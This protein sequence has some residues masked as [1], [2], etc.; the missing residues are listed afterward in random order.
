MYTFF[1]HLHHYLSYLLIAVIVFNLVRA[2]IGFWGKKSWNSTDNL[3]SLVMTI[4]TDVQVVFG[5]ILYVFLSPITKAAFANFGMAMQTSALRFYLVEH[6]ATM[7]IALALF[8]IGRSKAKKASL[9]S[10]KHKFSLI[11]TAIGTLFLL[12]RLP[13]DKLL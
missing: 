12:M 11:F 8:H 13:Y 1:L 10:A 5:L 3:A 6:I 2:G 7:L 9:H 4:L